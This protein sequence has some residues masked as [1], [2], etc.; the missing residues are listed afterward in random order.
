MAT[1]KSGSEAGKPRYRPSDRELA[2][3]QKC[4]DRDAVQPAPRLL[5][6]KSN[7]GATGLELDHPDARVGEA[8]LA[9]ALGTTDFDFLHGLIRQIANAAAPD[10]R[11]GEDRLNFLLS[12]VKG[13]RPMDQ[14]EAMLAAQM[15]AVHMSIMALGRRLA[16]VDS[17]PERDSIASAF[18]KC[19]RTF[20]SQL[21][22]LKRHRGGEQKITMQH[23]SVK[24]G[25]QA[26]V[27]DVSQAARAE[28]PSEYNAA[29]G[30]SP[31][32][33]ATVIREQRHDAT[34]PRRGKKDSGGWWR[35]Q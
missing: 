24:E 23:V 8:L 26:I 14:L 17:A 32:P 7:G 13:A 6:V 20:A 16:E 35:R 10:G 28:S 9:E 25:G 3:M 29:R 34:E 15:A 30:N 4:L 5:K 2:A 12:L 33:A 22:A 27:G 11:H 1:N 21:E 18:N 31:R 19:A